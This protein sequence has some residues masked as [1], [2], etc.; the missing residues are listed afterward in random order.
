VL[1]KLC[2]HNRCYLLSTLG[3]REGQISLLGYTV[4]DGGQRMGFIPYEEARGIVYVILGGEKRTTKFLYVVNT[5][6]DTYTLETTL[7]SNAVKAKW[8]GSRA[9]FTVD[10]EFGAKL[11]Y[12]S[13]R[14]TVTSEV[15]RQLKEQLTNQ[16]MEDVT[17]TIQTS[18]DYGC[19]YLY[20]S[21]PFRVTYPGIYEQMDWHSTFTN[22]NFSVNV[23]VTLK[24]HE[25]YDYSP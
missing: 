10:M 24:E 19:D 2:A 8:D 11:L 6:Q 25:S 14:G 12:Q 23:A 22:A 15:R 7:K 1:Q 5:G 16:L 17:Q 18:I 4:F 9:S 21:E 3:V 13:V 20:F